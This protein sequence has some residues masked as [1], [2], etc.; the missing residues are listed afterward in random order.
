VIRSAGCWDAHAWNPSS[1]HSKGKACDFFPGRAGRFASGAALAGGWQLAQWFR[2]NAAALRVRY[3]IWQGRY[4]DPSSGDKGG[5]G[6]RYD[7]GGIYHLADPT[8]GH[9]DHVH[10]SFVS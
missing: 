7:G 5:W 8:G 10:V 4:W 2:E 9:Y 3:V 6:T 1:D